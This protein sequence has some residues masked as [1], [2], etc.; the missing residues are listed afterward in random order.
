MDFGVKSLTTATLCA[1]A[2]CSA[3]TF[4]AWRN[5]NGLF[6]ETRAPGSN[7]RPWNR[8]SVLDVCVA[9][10]VSNLVQAG[11]SADNSVEVANSS[12]E[13]FL[14]AL[15]S[16]ARTAQ[17]QDENAK[18]RYGFFWIEDGALNARNGTIENILTLLSEDGQ[19]ETPM[20]EITLVLNYTYTAI[21]V[22]M[23]VE[24]LLDMDGPTIAENQVLSKQETHRLIHETLAEALRP[25]DDEGDSDA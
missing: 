16:L 4:R 15:T 17:E 13:I 20:P 23:E 2:G 19:S 14:E 18:D 6:P 5:R 3:A 9:R 24:S 10:T 21:Y 1:V 11:F 7:A 22:I 12:S 25:K 8:F